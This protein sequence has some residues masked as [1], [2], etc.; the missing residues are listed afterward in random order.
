MA[1]VCF[2][3]TKQWLHGSIRPVM[4]LLKEHVIQEICDGV[5]GLHRFLLGNMVAPNV[6][7]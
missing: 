2:P 6:Y 4:C 3:K 1:D 7:F 5:L